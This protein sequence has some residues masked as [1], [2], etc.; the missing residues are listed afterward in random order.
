M[1]SPPLAG[2]T[3]NYIARVTN[4]D[5]A[6]QELRVSS[7]GSAV[8]WMRGQASPEVWRVTFE[9]SADGVT[10]TSLG[11]G[12]RITGGW[13]LT[14]LSLPVNQNHYVRARGY[15]TG[16]YQN[17][18]GSLF[19]SVRIFY[20]KPIGPIVDFDGDG[21]TDVAA[22]HLPSDQFFTDYAGNL[23]QYGWGGA[24][25]YPVVW[26]Y[27]NNGATDISIY[28]IPTNQWFVKGV[29][30]DNLGAFGWGEDESV[31]VPGDYDGDGL[32]DRAFYHWPT[33]RWFVEEA[34]GSFTAYDFGWGGADCIPIALDY[35][36]D[37]TTDMMLYHIPSNQWFVYG[38]GNL[39]QFGWNGSECLPVP[40]DWDGDGEIDLAIYHW[41]SNEWVWRDK[42]GTAHFLGQYGWGGMASFPI[43]G[44]YDG[45]GV[46]ERAFYRPSENRWFIEGEADFVWGWGGSDF[47]PITSQI[48][49]YNWF[50]FVLGMFQ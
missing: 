8:T 9:H 17:G 28:H 13:Q 10:W 30:G 27:D 21:S 37:G 26:D 20:L 31:P 3:R 33:N 23:G 2:C 25:C 14:G 47:M 32:I 40:G 48:T 11:N 49:I 18:S 15:A 5:A 19:E 7:N 12:T 16:G 43:P 6:L 46:M 38:I 1:I 35:D 24:D 4:T 44:D 42:S 34:G 39:G 22:F 50:R 41:P 45:N 29:P 36:G